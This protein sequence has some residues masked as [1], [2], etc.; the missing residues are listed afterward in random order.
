MASPSKAKAKVMGPTVPPSGT[1]ILPPKLTLK[2]ALHW[3]VT[4]FK[5]IKPLSSLCNIAQF[6]QV[7]VSV[8]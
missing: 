7:T 8:K 5:R 2:R 4:P 1:A 6:P 3:L